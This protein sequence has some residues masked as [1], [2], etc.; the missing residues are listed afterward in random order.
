MYLHCMVLWFMFLLL[1]LSAMAEE[2]LKREERS[3]APA[4]AQMKLKNYSTAQKIAAELPEDCQRDLLLGVAALK[5]GRNGEAAELLGRAAKN[6]PLLADYALLYQAEASR[7]AGQSAEAVLILQALQKGHPDSP[8]LKKS[9]LMEADTAFDSGAYPQAAWRYQKFIEKYPAGSDSLQASY[10]LALC[11]EKSGDGAGAAAI[12]RSLWLNSPASVQAAQA[13]EELQRLTAAGIVVKPFSSQELFKRATT[14]YEQRRYDLALATLRGIDTRVEKKDFIDQVALKTG[15]ALLKSRQYNDAEKCLQELS[16]SA[17]KVEVMSAAAYLMARS[18]EKSGRSEEA[19]NAYTLIAAVFPKSAEADNALLDAAFI[20]KFQYRP[21]ETAALLENLLTAY[22]QTRLKNR[23]AW[24]SGWA[25]YLA[26]NYSGAA[27]QFSM[28]LTIAGYREKALFWHGRSS[29]AAGDAAAAEADFAA[30]RQEFPFGFYSLAAQAG[31]GAA[32]VETIPTLAGVL[33]EMLPLPDGFER[34]KALLA[35]G[36]SDDAATELAAGRKKLAKTKGDAGLARLYLELGSYNR[37]MSLYNASLLNH[38]PESKNAWLF[39]YPQAFKDLVSTYSEQAG[40]KPSL[41][42]AIMRAESSF[43]ATAASPVGA[44]GLMQLMPQTAAMI[45]KTK[46]IEPQ[47][48]YAPELNIR[49]GTRHLRELLD[50]YNGNEIAVIA[51]YNAGAGNVNRWLK[52]YA[53]LSGAEFI[54]SIPFGET[55]EYVKKVLAAAS[56]YKRLYGIN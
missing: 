32:Q 51:S 39:L 38:S 31:G 45:L 42:Y 41:A 53:N 47:K 12:F 17:A 46:K 11:R 56:L 30:L 7:K 19:F 23:I 15:Q 44:R 6:Y 25:E 3:L 2:A 1:P 34:V 16:R 49:L 33:P 36:L 50:T 40:V 27:E 52:T 29:A 22:P 4:A 24:E 37:A 21:K 43:S 48:L 35:L 9:L 14:L 28:L 10:R 5:R 55:R 13:G 8:L 20:R 54:E 26:G 18:I